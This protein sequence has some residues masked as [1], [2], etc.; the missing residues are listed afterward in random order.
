MITESKMDY[1]D[2]LKL[3]GATGKETSAEMSKLFKRASLKNHPDR[4]G[5]TEAMQK[6]NQAYT[7]A[8]RVSSTNSIDQMN[9]YRANREREAKEFYD[10]LDQL[11]AKSK[12]Y[13]EHRFNAQEFADYFTSFTGKPT[14][15]TYD[16]VRN[17]HNIGIGYKFVS[18]DGHFD[19]SFWVSPNTTKGGLS[20]PDSSSLGNVTVATG[21]LVGTK[22]YK[23]ASR[24][25]DWKGRNPDR[26]TPESLFPKAKMKAIFAPSAAKAGKAKVYKRAD[27]MASFSKLLDAKISGNDIDI[28]VGDFTIKMYR[29]V[30]MRQGYYSFYGVYAPHTSGKFKTRVEHLSGMLFEDPQGDTLNFILELMQ[31]MQKEKP[32][33]SAKLAQ[34]VQHAVKNR[35]AVLSQQQ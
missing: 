13:F 4:G 10:R 1:R 6:I 15:F 3:L 12:A 27:Y 9:D 35:E 24:E 16:I 34:I 32:A 11:H 21:V 14:T 5:S 31:K 2:A 25:Y 26:I 22:K 19:F 18:G 7:I 23:M 20:A 29:N 17:T 8:S 30:M 33:T 28:D